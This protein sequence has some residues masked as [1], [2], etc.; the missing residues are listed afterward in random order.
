MR[1]GLEPQFICHP[2]SQHLSLS[3][4]LGCLLLISFPTSLTYSCSL[5]LAWLHTPG[6]APRQLT[7][8]FR[9]SCASK[10]GEAWVLQL[11]IPSRGLNSGTEEDGSVRLGSLHCPRM[12]L[13]QFWWMTLVGPASYSSLTQLKRTSW[14]RDCIPFRLTIVID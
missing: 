8:S 10:G 4:V 9:A 11:P 6:P 1:S 14:W 2:I 7:P 13:S 3:W 12:P 5:S